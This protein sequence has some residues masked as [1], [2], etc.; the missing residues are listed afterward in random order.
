MQERF[1]GAHYSLGNG[2]WLVAGNGTAREISERLG[3]TPDAENGTGIVLE[4]ASY[5]GRANP[6]VWSWIKESW[7][8]RHYG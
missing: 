5:Y 1:P 8:R 7:E 3:I 2:V 6:A 4:T